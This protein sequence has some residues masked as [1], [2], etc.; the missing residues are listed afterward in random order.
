MLV[1]KGAFAR[2]RCSDLARLRLRKSLFLLGSGGLASP[3]G[4][5]RKGPLAFASGAC[6]RGKPEGD[7]SGTNVGA[8]VGQGVTATSIAR[9]AVDA[10]L[11]DATRRL[12]ARRRGE[13]LVQ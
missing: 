3:P 10:E 6:D 13:T 8:T 4:G 5:S 11:Y 12:L 1:A 2:D 9:F 7:E